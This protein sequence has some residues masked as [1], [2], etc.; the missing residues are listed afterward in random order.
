MDPDN[1]G[2]RKVKQSD[3]KILATIIRDV[4]EEMD[5]PKSGSVYS[6]PSTDHLYELFLH[7]GSA[8]WVAEYGNN[9]VG[10][11]GI[12]PTSGL[13]KGW[14]ELVKFYLSSEARGKGIGRLLMEKCIASALEYHYKTLYLESFPIFTN[15]IKLYEKFGFNPIPAPAGNSGHIACTIWMSKELQK[16]P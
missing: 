13:P 4:F 6:D 12:Y 11:C 1:L 15:A 9:I 16:L 14:V 7:P 10:C 3:N 5:A 2:L 8:L